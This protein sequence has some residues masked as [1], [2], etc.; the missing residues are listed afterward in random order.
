MKIAKELR[1]ADEP[2]VY[3]LDEPTT[4][5]HPSDIARLVSVLDD[6]V[7][8][9]HTVV[10]IE[11]NLDVIRRA[12]WLI[13]LGPGPGRHGGRVLYAGRVDGIGD[14]ATG[15]ALRADAVAPV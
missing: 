14:T 5:L 11:H 9:G 13:D 15:D 1:D 12:D 8:H 4:G 10:V 2:S 3:V 7:E 6:L